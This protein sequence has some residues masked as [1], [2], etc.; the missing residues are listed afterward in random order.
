MKRINIIVAME[1]IPESEAVM[2]EINSKLMR[3]EPVK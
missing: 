1:L 2:V 3:A